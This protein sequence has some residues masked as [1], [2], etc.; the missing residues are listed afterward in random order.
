MGKNAQQLRSKDVA[1]YGLT[2]N[3]VDVETAN[4]DP[5]TICQVGIAHVVDG[6]VDDIWGT[7]VDPEV[8]FNR[9]HIKI[10]GITPDKVKG[11]RTLPEIREVP[12]CNDLMP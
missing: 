8:Q 3:A 9:R 7:L 2:F 11:A 5:S 4:S 12:R 6:K 1:G 10:H